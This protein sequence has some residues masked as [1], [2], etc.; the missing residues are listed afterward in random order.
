MRCVANRKLGALED[1]LIDRALVWCRCCADGAAAT[2]NA[3]DNSP[4]RDS[5]TANITALGAGVLVVVL[6][7]VGNNTG[8]H[9]SF[10]SP[11]TIFRA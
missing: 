3:F 8:L 10:M 1:I 11:F 6:A 9:R 5:E 7:I 2:A 4:L